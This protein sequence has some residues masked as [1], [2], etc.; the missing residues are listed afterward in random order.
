MKNSRRAIGLL[1]TIVLVASTLGADGSCALTMIGEPVPTSS[2]ASATTGGA[3]DMSSGAGAGGSLPTGTGG[4]PASWCGG[5]GDSCDAVLCCDPFECAAGT[6]DVAPP[7][8]PPEPGSGDTYSSCV[9][10][11]NCPS[12]GSVNGF[13]AEVFVFETTV[14]DDGKDAAGGWQVSGAM[15]KYARLPS[16]GIIPD[17]WSCSVVIGMPLRTAV[18]GIVPPDQAANMSAG[19][20]TAASTV[21]EHGGPK[22]PPGIF[23]SKLKPTMQGLWNQVFPTIGAKMM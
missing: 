17:T 8:P 7:A 2:G 19:I 6:C 3:C 11:C 1:L 5:L 23:C 12:A 18:N 16:F 15:L 13:A 20:A 9:D 10:P 21:L 14:K 22:L 4:A